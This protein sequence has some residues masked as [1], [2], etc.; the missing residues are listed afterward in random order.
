MEKGTRIKYC[1]GLYCGKEIIETAYILQDDGGEYIWI[2][3][4]KKSLNDGFGCTIL[5]SELR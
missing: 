4:S 1:S 2:S 3:K 5:R